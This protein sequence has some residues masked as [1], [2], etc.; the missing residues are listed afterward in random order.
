MIHPDLYDELEWFLRCEELS[1][2]TSLL[3]MSSFDMNSILQGC[4]LHCVDK[5]RS[6][7]Y[8]EKIIKDVPLPKYERTDTCFTLINEREESSQA[9][10]IVSKPGYVVK[11][12]SMPL[13]PKEGKKKKKKKKK[14]KRRKRREEKVSSPRYVSPKVVSYDSELDDEPMPITYIS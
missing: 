13:P 2:K 10:S 12:L 4:R 7:L 6:N 3:D 14:K 9:S 1:R 5:S 8:L 11:L